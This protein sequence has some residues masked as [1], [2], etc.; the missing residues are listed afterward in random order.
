VLVESCFAFNGDSDL[1]YRNRAIALMKAYIRSIDKLGFFVAIPSSPRP[2]NIAASEN[3]CAQSRTVNLC[4]PTT[5]QNGD[6]DS[7]LSIQ[8]IVKPGST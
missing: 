7:G 1:Q 4:L 5:L 3:M 2:T 6:I 8:S